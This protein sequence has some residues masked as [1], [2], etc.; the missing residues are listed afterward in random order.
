MEMEDN[1]TRVWAVVGDDPIT[2]LSDPSL[3]CYLLDSTEN[4][5]HQ[6]R[7][8][9]GNLV[10]RWDVL[11]GD[12]QKVDRRLWVD[13]LKGEH[14]VVLIDLGRRNLPPD[15]LTKEAIGGQTNHSKGVQLRTSYGAPSETPTYSTKSLTNYSTRR[16]RIPL[17]STRL[18]RKCG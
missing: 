7:I 16:R 18:C 1:L 9:C 11:L 4:L 13:V 10:N 15:D 6:G 5:A 14:M 3:R 2:R 17:E 12:H 8:S